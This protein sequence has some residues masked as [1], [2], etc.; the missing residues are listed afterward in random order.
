VRE[1]TTLNWSETPYDDHNRP[2][3]RRSHLLTAVALDL[4]DPG[5][6]WPAGLAVVHLRVHPTRTLPVT[7]ETVTVGLRVLSVE[8]LQDAPSLLDAV[9]R[10][11]LAARRHA[12]ILAAHALTAS[13]DALSAYAA[14][15]HPRPPTPALVALG[16][17]WRARETARRGA[18]RFYDTATDTLA[19]AGRVAVENE[20]M[21]AS[22][23]DLRDLCAAHGVD[24]AVGVGVDGADAA[25]T[26][27]PGADARHFALACRALA[28]GLLTAR[29]DSRYLWDGALSVTGVLRDHAWDQ[30]GPGLAQA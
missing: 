14:T 9:D 17:E 3:T 8:R 30:F 22:P 28:I 20:G 1:I 7:P 25:A 6:P 13:L 2:F 10:T 21:A 4:A 29:A 15:L 23:G 24:L 11:L 19:V 18:A 5:T 12:V 26:C 16:A 27:E